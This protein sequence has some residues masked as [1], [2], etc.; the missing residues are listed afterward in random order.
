MALLSFL[1]CAAS[2]L[3]VRA[4][5]EREVQRQSREAVDA[6]VRAFTQ[7][8]RQEDSQLLRTA[9]LLSE[10]PTLKALMTAPDTLTVQDGSQEFWALSGSDLLVLANAQGQVMASHSEVP[11]VDAAS[12]HSI[13]KKSLNEGQQI[14]WWQSGSNLYR[15]TVQAITAGAGGD[16]RVLGELVL[17]KQ[18]D[19]LVAEQI[20]HFS[21]NEITLISGNSVIASTLGPQ[22]QRY[23]AAMLQHDQLSSTFNPRRY[24]IGNLPYEAATVI[25]QT[26]PAT[27]IRCLILSPLEST[28]VFLRNLNSTIVVLGILIGLL[29]A[30]IMML[31]S[32]AITGPLETLVAAV[33]AMAAGDDTYSVPA[34]GT[35][36]VTQLSAAFGRMRLE[37]AE[38]RRKQLEAERMAA[39]GR[40]AGS[41][42]HDLRH[43]LAAVIANAEFLRDADEIGCDR[44]EV[45]DE[46][47]K[48]SAQMTGLIDSLIEVAR[49]GH[50]LRLANTSVAE[51][52]SH[53]VALVQ[54][55]R[56]FRSRN[57]EIS[58][59][60]DTEG[61]FD[62]SRL[63]RAIF[64]LLLN[65][66][67]AVDP[68]TGN[69]HIAVTSDHDFIDFSISDN[70]PGLPLDVRDKIFQP[71][72]T[73][74]KPNGTGLGLA[75]AWKIVNDHHG[76]L[77]LREASPSGAAFAI[78]LPRWGSQPPPP[79]V[80]TTDG[81][82][83]QPGAEVPEAGTR[84]VH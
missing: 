72:V 22:D 36:E 25:L 70:G 24:E 33:K 62:G 64:N 73:G 76:Q 1:L 3:I 56:E 55:N 58:I 66:C 26:T 39:L 51:I 74:E 20:R 48:A 84:A 81:A 78:R 41:I 65:A 79:E 9:A 63:E 77:L 82:D 46:L 6:S 54:N 40:A 44:N 59:A 18:I 68:V 83:L 31:I 53:A 19:N 7:F 67:Q 80:K 8:Q 69:I 42:S 43:I 49:E 45:Y 57:I 35:A 14:G 75:I 52:V 37:V 11:Q 71:F 4:S 10:L 17:G 15:V 38:S 28:D 5:V 21:G 50:H 32:S 30:A 27:P 2:L 29:G 23:L 12:A 34:N 16:Q 60:G 13:F 47:Q 61:I